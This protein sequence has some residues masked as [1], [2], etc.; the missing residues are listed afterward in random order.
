MT[1]MNITSEGQ[2]AFRD[3]RYDASED[4]LSPRMHNL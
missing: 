2:M 3:L 1:K 4:I